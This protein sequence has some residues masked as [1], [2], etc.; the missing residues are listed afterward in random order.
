MF[1]QHC[2][3]MLGRIFFMIKY[4]RVGKRKPKRFG[5]TFRSTMEIRTGRIE[6]RS[7]EM[8]SVR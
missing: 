6:L 3:S 5:M 4:L 8:L 7:E 2:P 1:A